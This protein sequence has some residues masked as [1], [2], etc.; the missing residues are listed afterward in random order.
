[1]KQPPAPLQNLSISNA[2]PDVF[3]SI[4]KKSVLLYTRSFIPCTRW[5]FR[6]AEHWRSAEQALH[7]SQEGSQGAALSP[8]CRME[9]Q[10]LSR[11]LLQP[12]RE[13]VRQLWFWSTFS[14]FFFCFLINFSRE[15][16]LIN[17]SGLHHFRMTVLVCY[18]YSKLIAW[19]P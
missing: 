12:R 1:M 8:S 5:R 4:L 18:F 3:F 16:T 14:L 19:L 2:I 13:L 6:A 7:R 17:P 15:R 11:F 9:L 10:G